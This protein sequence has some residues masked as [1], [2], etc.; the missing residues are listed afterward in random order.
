MPAPL[1]PILASTALRTGGTTVARTGAQTLGRT[2]PNA[3]PGVVGNGARAF[4]TQTPVNTLRASAGPTAGRNAALPM[5]NGPNATSATTAARPNAFSNAGRPTASNGAQQAAQPG[6]RQQAR[7][8]ATDTAKDMAIG[9]MQDKA[10]QSIEHTGLPVS[11]LGAIPTSGPAAAASIVSTVMP[12]ATQAFAQQ[13]TPA[14]T[15]QPPT[16]PGTPKT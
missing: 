15:S 14:A 7:Q 16:A 6:F 12:M 5:R 13:R 4:G 1:I 9:H 2:A 10:L 8:F 3:A 11:M